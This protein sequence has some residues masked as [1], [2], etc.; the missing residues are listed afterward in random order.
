KTFP[1]GADVLLWANTAENLELTFL[2]MG[3]T[4]HLPI[5]VASWFGPM[6]GAINSRD[7]VGHLKKTYYWTAGDKSEM[8]RMLDLGVDGLIVDDHLGLEEVLVE[9]PYRTLFRKATLDDSQFDA[10]GF[11][12]G[13]AN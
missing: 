2:G 7:R 13:P 9:E 5:D 4:Q 12:Y 10:H 6:S 3:I 8:R 11:P 1:M